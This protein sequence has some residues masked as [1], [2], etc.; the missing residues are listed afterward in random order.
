M[1]GWKYIILW[2]GVL[3]F[4]ESVIYNVFGLYD[5]N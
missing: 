4:N 3:G 1:F 5:Y 2:F